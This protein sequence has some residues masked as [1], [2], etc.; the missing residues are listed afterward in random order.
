MKVV[1]ML[2]A[3]GSFLFFTGSCNELCC[4]ACSPSVSREEMAESARLLT[5]FST[6]YSEENRAREHNLKLACERISGTVLFE[7]AEFSF[8]ACVGERTKENGFL[9]AAVISGGEYV[10]G[11]GG[12]VCQVSSTLFCAALLSGMRITES[13]SHS[14]AVGYVSPSLDAMVSRLSDLKFVNHSG[15]PIY[16]KA[17]AQNGIVTVAVYGLPN[18]KRYETESIV[19]YELLPPED[20]VEEGET[21]EVMRI[22]KK[23]LVSESY[24]LIYDQYGCLLSRTLIRKDSYAPIRGVVRKKTQKNMEKDQKNG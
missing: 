24:L 5:C 23:G 19:L 6:E 2:L 15:A 4:F 12:G 16:I 20:I 21:D 14:L 13:H 22:S 3:M 17:E 10:L 18:E 8:N 1:R 9:D 11:V 7:Q